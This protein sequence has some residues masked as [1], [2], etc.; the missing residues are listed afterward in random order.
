[1]SASNM[2]DKPIYMTINVITDTVYQS[3]CVHDASEP[4]CSQ[5]IKDIEQQYEGYK[6]LSV[7][8][9]IKPRYRGNHLDFIFLHTIPL[10][11]TNRKVIPTTSYDTSEWDKAAQKWDNDCCIM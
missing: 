8:T 2:D 10:I 1:M 4:K 7:D 11:E 9:K 6:V 5:F 3:P